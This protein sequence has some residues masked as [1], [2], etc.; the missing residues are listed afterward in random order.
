MYVPQNDQ[1][2]QRKATLRGGGGGASTLSTVQGTADSTASTNVVGGAGGGGPLDSTVSSFPAARAGAGSKSAAA[3]T[4]DLPAQRPRPYETLLANSFMEFD[5]DRRLHGRSGGR[6]GGGGGGG[7]VVSA[8][9]HT[10]G[11]HYAGRGWR[12]QPLTTA[13]T[14]HSKPI[15]FQATS[16]NHGGEECPAGKCWQDPQHHQ[17]QQ[18]QPRV[19]RRPSTAGAGTGGVPG[20]L[21][22]LG[23]Y[24]KVTIHSQMLF[25]WWGEEWRGG[26]GGVLFF[27]FSLA[28]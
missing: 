13:S 15:G 26:G 23:G 3:T 5:G 9:P 19:E 25:I 28:F 24:E 1:Q 7:G 2:E 18:S 20:V 4:S 11:S 10:A 6:G 21:A 12:K 27:F 16:T 8:R 14:A 17:R 22:R